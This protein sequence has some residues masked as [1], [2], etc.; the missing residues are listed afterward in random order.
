[1]AEFAQV[2]F[3][4]TATPTAR[5]ALSA[6]AMQWSEAAQDWDPAKFAAIY[7]DDALFFGGQPTLYVGADQI[8]GYFATQVGIIHS[9]TL[10]LV[11]QHVR[12]LANGIFLAQ[13]RGIS[14]VQLVSGLARESVQRTTW[15]V[16]QQGSQWKLAQHH[17]SNG[18]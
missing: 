3:A 2:E 18:A 4:D 10:R 13:G 16:V 8:R 1:M 15:V 6:V 14:R 17:F 9:V 12:E 7:T 5:A 11:D